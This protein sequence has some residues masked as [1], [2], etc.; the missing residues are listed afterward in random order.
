MFSGRY[1]CLQRLWHSA[2][3]EYCVS[4]LDDQGLSCVKT[5]G[6]GVDTTGRA[7]PD[8]QLG[9]A[10]CHGYVPYGCAACLKRANNTASSVA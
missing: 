1:H 4:R 10:C 9:G 2:L 7:Q 3:A 6:R 5:A 8:L